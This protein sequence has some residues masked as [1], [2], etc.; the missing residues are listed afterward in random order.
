MKFGWE[1]DL[2]FLDVSLS[3]LLEISIWING[4]FLISNN[5]FIRDGVYNKLKIDRCKDWFG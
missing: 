5:F 1:K 3:S 4:I 2:F